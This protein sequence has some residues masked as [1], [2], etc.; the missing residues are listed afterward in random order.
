[1]FSFLNQ[2]S[3]AFLCLQLL[4]FSVLIKPSLHLDF[5]YDSCKCFLLNVTSN[6]IEAKSQII[7]SS[8][9]I[10]SLN[11][12]EYL[13]PFPYQNTIFNKLDES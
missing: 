9:I 13:L 3:Q 4:H 2:I 7:I 1:M 6:S 10:N 8:H 5:L 12:F 11:D